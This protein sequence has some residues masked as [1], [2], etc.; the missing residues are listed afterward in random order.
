MAFLQYTN[1][2]P[3]ASSIPPETYNLDYYLMTRPSNATIQTKLILD[4]QTNV[5]LYPTFH[6]YFRERQPPVLAVWGKNDTIFVPAG[7]EAFKKDLP[8][9][10][11]KFVDGGHFAL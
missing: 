11:V 4:Y 7:A 1:G 5:E 8:K 9:A 6:K 10:V 2:A 3:N